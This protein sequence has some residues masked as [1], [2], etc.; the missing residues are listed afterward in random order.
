MCE[1]LRVV[2]GI[3]MTGEKMIRIGLA[4]EG[5]SVGAAIIARFAAQQ[6]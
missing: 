6:M 4:K 2:D 3:E 5:S 1:V